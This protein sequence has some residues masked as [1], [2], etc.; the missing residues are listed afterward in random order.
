MTLREFEA[1]LKNAYENT[2]ETAAPKG[3]LD[4]VVWQRYGTQPGFGDDCNLFGLPKVQI[5]IVTQTRDSIIADDV[6]AALWAMNLPYS[7][8]SEGYDPE[9]NAF[10]TILQA[11]VI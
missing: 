2:Y 7:V 8:Q 11:V 9:Y 1:Q 4:Y 6:M 5:E 3:Q 10:R